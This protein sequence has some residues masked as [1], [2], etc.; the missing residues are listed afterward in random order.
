MRSCQNE[1]GRGARLC[2][3]VPSCCCK[4]KPCPAKK[5]RRSGP[6]SCSRARPLF[7]R[8]SRAHSVQPHSSP[9]VPGTSSLILSTGRSRSSLPMRLRPTGGIFCPPGPCSTTA[10]RAASFPNLPAS[11]CARGHAAGSA[12]DFVGGRRLT[13]LRRG[14]PPRYT[15]VGKSGA[16]VDASI[17][18]SPK[19][20]T[21]R[22]VSTT[23]TSS[24]PASR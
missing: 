14:R 21:C 1:T 10:G 15:A 8:W 18:S 13:P 7:S 11:P 4:V 3:R 5:K 9:V 6:F 2:S 12:N 17:S 20:R 23:Q 24:A 22:S 16:S 19:N